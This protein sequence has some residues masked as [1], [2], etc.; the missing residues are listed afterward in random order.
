VNNLQLWG[1]YNNK[2]WCWRD[3]YLPG[4]ASRVYI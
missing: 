1:V 4:H 3:D 2:W